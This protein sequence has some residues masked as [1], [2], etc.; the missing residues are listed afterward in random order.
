ME[1]VV[2]K[3][4]KGNGNNGVIQMR[5]VKSRPMPDEI[6]NKVL[7]EHMQ[8][9]KYELKQEMKDMKQEIHGVK[10]DLSRL[11]QKVD[12][13]FEEASQHRQALQEDLTAT[14]QDTINIRRHIG[15]PVASE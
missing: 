11:E 10:S 5:T 2:C 1:G 3:G 7:L 6:T 15:M 8:G 14:I 4:G 9:I 12:R 13:G